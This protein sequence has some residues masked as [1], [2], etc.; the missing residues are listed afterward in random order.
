MIYWKNL[1]KIAFLCCISS[2]L[3]ASKNVEKSSILLISSISRIILFCFW[4]PPPQNVIVLR[5]IPCLHFSLTGKL[6]EMQWRS[7]IFLHPNKSH[8]SYT[9]NHLPARKNVDMEFI[10]FLTIFSLVIL[11]KKSPG[12]QR[13]N[14]YTHI[15]LSYKM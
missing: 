14:T 13:V 8:S 10:C 6:F 4:T 7:L 5:W 9:S 11:I 2:N 3:L 1:T 12:S 15:I